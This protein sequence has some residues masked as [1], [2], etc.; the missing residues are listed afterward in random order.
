V[1]AHHKSANSALIDGGRYTKGLYVNKYITDIARLRRLNVM[2]AT[3]YDS[4]YII[5]DYDI[6]LNEILLF[7]IILLFFDQGEQGNMAV[8]REKEKKI[9]IRLFQNQEDGYLRYLRAIRSCGKRQRVT[10]HH[11]KFTGYVDG[12]KVQRGSDPDTSVNQ[13]VLWHGF[14][15]GVPCCI[16]HNDL[17]CR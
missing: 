15:G 12:K 3:H 5:T 2:I 14:A 16:S 8:K 17:Y 7:M 11:K 4:G 10:A 6:Y 13:E 1:P 9:I